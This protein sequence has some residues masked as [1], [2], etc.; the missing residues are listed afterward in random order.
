WG[1]LGEMPERPN[2]VK[3]KLTSKVEDR[4]GYTL[5]RFEFFNGVDNTVPGVMLIPKGV[6][7]PVPAIVLLHGHG[8]SKESCCTD[9][10]N[11]QYVG[12]MLARKGYVVAAI[13]SYFCGGRIGQ[14]PGG[15]AEGK[16]TPEASLFKLNLW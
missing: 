11:V 3:V 2:P 12:P 14:G 10:K 4:D 16:G 13:D 1:C 7:G 6:K 8:S 5:E 15:K 9:E